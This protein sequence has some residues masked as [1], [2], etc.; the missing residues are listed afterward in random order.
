MPMPEKST[1]VR[2]VSVKDK[3]YKILEGWIIDGTLLPGEKISDLE[4]AKH[5]NVSRTPVREAFHQLEMQKLIESYPG[6]ATIVSAIQTD[7]LEQYYLPLSV[8]QGLAAKLACENMTRDSF[9]ELTSLN[10][11]FKAALTSNDLVMTGKYD[12]EFHKCIIHLSG[13][14]YII[15]FCEILNLHVKRLCFLSFKNN[16][17]AEDSVTQHEDIIRAFEKKDA[18]LVSTLVEKNIMTA[19]NRIKSMLEQTR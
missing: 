4:I 11:K 6:K 18:E 12:E 19:M 2:R 17:A 9:K 16:I 13:N 14:P 8:L 5:F 3:I 7:N 1:P 15:D 10:N